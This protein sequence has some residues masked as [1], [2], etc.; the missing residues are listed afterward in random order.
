MEVLG[1]NMGQILEHEFECDQCGRVVSVIGVFGDV[2]HKLF[3]CLRRKS[4][5]DKH[6]LESVDHNPNN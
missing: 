5:V 6:D 4:E 1:N 3:T 2:Y